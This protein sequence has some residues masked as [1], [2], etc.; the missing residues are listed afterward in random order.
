MTSSTLLETEPLSAEEQTLEKVARILRKGI[1]TQAVITVALFLLTVFLPAT[2]LESLRALML[3]NFGA[4]AE[5]SFVAVI[6]V[7]LFNISLFLVLMVGV[8]SREI[9]AFIATG[10]ILLVNGALLVTWGFIPLIIPMIFLAWALAMMFP[11]LSI[12][13][14]NPITLKELR[15]RMRGARAFLVLTVY[16]GLMS[17]FMLLIYF[18]QRSAVI[19]A[20]SVATGEVG[21]IL[22]MSVVG[23]ELLLIIFITPGFTSG[24]ITSEREHQTYD[25]LRTTLI[26]PSTFIIG[27]LESALGYVFLLLLAGIPLQSVAFLFGGI[28]EL[29][30]IL[31][32]VVLLAT[33]MALGAVGIYFSAVYPK[34][35]TANIRAHSTVIGVIVGSIAVSFILELFYGMLVFNGTMPNSLVERILI[36]ARTILQSINPILAS[37]T[38]QS[39]WS[40]YQSISF[41][42]YTLVSDGST[43]PLISP[44]L[45]FTL[46][47]LGGAA[48]LLILA[49]RRTRSF[50]Q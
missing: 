36:Y 3:A 12:F 14:T 23:I 19:Y 42:N 27:K 4:D 44:W 34:T 2:L 26:A 1:M 33:A 49:I 6:L 29:E 24:A 22:F 41:W 9:W 18:L 32:L 5:T 7:M 46:I 30:I 43:M 10:I 11:S 37:L 20:N 16:L 48:C 21:R 17:G 47:Y 31:S 25:L 50:D 15:G 28:S 35:F 13:R 8:L 40:E 38:S 45:L 39:I